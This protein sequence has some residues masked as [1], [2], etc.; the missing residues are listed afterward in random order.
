MFRS[1]G[2]HIQHEIASTLY[3]PV[4]RYFYITQLFVLFILWILYEVMWDFSPVSASTAT[5]LNEFHHVPCTCAMRRDMSELLTNGQCVPDVTLKI[6][7]EE[8]YAHRCILCARSSV[9]RAMFASPMVFVRI[10]MIS[11]GWSDVT[12]QFKHTI[13]I[14]YRNQLKNQIFLFVALPLWKFWNSRYSILS[15]RRK[16]SCS[17]IFDCMYVRFTNIVLWL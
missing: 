11:G 4:V 7:A 1:T 2:Q 16:G 14:G 17:S 13:F 5:A 6:G 15:E 3:L 12:G 8:I 10:F 9:F